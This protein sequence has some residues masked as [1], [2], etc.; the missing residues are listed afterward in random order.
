MVRNTENLH[1]W[2]DMTR[3][4]LVSLVTAAK[5][6]QLPRMGLPY[7]LTITHSAVFS[8]INRHPVAFLGILL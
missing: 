7:V 2:Q 4:C 5:L 6:V 1:S 3:F 8:L